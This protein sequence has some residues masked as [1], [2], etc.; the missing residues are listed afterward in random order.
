MIMLDGE[1]FTREIKDKWVGRE[2]TVSKTTP[3]P[4]IRIKIEDVRMA[5]WDG[6][7]RRIQEKHGRETRFFVVSGAVQA[8]EQGEKRGNVDQY[9][10]I[11][12]DVNTAYDVRDDRLVVLTDREVVEFSPGR[13]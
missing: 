7:D 1:N 4:K 9:L 11:P 8:G 6:M 12:V 5:G 3:T 13:H 10:V 2:V